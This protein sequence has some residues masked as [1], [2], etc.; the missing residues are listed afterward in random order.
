MD[1]LR[2]GV[3]GSALR[4]N[5]NAEPRFRGGDKKNEMSDQS[6]SFTARGPEISGGLSL[7]QHSYGPIYE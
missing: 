1:K 2:Q 4:T 5:V 3:R 7:E 6:C